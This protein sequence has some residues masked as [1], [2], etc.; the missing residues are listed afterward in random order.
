[1]THSELN[2]QY[3][4]IDS[5]RGQKLEKVGKYLLV[6]PSAQAVWTQK[7]PPSEW[8]NADA[9]FVRKAGGDGTWKINNP[10]LPKSWNIQI[11]SV[12]FIIKLTDFG[13]IGIF[14]EQHVMWKELAKIVCKERAETKGQGDFS[15]INLFAYTGGAT[16]FLAEAGASVVHVDASRTSVQWARDNAKASG[17]EHL[18]VRWMIDDAFKFVTKEARRGKKYHGIVLDPPSYGRGPKGEVWKIDERMSELLFELKKIFHPKFSFLFLTA[19]STGF[20]PL[21]LKNL[22]LET[23]DGLPGKV[24]ASEMTLSS[25]TSKSDLPSGSMSLFR[26]DDSE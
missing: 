5:G 10:A 23:C 22:L 16:L 17:F 20:S 18:R 21:V 1:M 24:I 4:L 15:V 19:H 3:Q 6:R 14:P 12:T 11:G 2:S 8:K 26:R 7:L 9:V 13:H 25:T